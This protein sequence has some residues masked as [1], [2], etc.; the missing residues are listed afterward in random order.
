MIEKGQIIYCENGHPMYRAIKGTRLGEVLMA[1]SFE[2]VDP[3]VGKPAYGH[4]ILP[5][6]RCGTKPVF[7]GG[8]FE[9]G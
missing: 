1:G 4:V 5:C 3:A 8:G 7:K 9:S 6:P 2:S